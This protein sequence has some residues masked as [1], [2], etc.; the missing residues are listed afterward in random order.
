MI[1]ADSLVVD[2]LLHF[3]ARLRIELT[4]FLAVG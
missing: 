4:A 2:K 3:E 1:V